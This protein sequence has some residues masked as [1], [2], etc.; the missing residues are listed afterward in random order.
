MSIKSEDLL[1][2]AKKAG[3]WFV[4]RQAEKGNYVGNEKPDGNGIYPD[5]HDVGCYYKSVHFLNAVGERLAAAKAVNYVVENFMSSEGDFFNTPENRTSGSYTPTYCQLYPNM[6]I[7]RALVG[8]DRYDLSRRVLDFLKKHRDPKTGGFYYS[9]TPPK[10]VIDSNATGYGIF[11]QL[12]GGDLKSAVQSGELILRMLKEQPES[13]R[14]YLRWTEQGGYETDFTGIP[15][16]HLIYCV[17]DAKKPAQAYWCWGWPMNGLIKLYD[18]TGRQRYLDGAIEIYDF[19]A[20]CH[21]NAFHFTTAGKD[22][23]GSS[24]LY[25]ITGDKRYLKTALSQMEFIL[26]SQQPEGYMLGPGAKSF[27]DQALR[28]TYDFTA[29]FSSWLVGVSMELAGRE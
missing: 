20:S 27:D 16:K 6:W 25:R 26:D 5:T 14:F 24:M 23:W 1:A 13:D 8:M 22:G 11:I 4:S 3:Q 15:E 7:M 2:A 9:V 10:K 19:L 29:D 28:T 17:I 12:L 18:R 21:E